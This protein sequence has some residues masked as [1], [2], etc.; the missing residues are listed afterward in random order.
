MFLSAEP[1]DRTRLLLAREFREIREELLNSRERDRFILKLPEFSLRPQYITRALLDA[2]AQIIHFSGHGKTG[3]QLYFETESGDSLPF[4]PGILEDLFKQFS[5][6]IRCV[7]LNACFA[8]KQ[9]KALSKYIDYV[10]G[11][12]AG[13]SDAAAMA[14]S[15]GFYHALGAG[16][17]I[18]DSFQ[19]GL[20]Q[21]GLQNTPEYQI[22]VLFKRNK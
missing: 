22:P 9:A 7:V 1:T 4:E 15:I 8:E 6:K 19:H 12:Q 3:E 21:S 16:K 10:I 5:G 13:I 14:F 20:I 11:I 18:E 17:N 2:N